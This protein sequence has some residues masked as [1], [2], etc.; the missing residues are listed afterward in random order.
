MKSWLPII[1][2]AIVVAETLVAVFGLCGCSSAIT[3]GS[4]H[5]VD[6][7]ANTTTGATTT[8]AR[9]TVVIVSP[10][11]GVE[12]RSGTAAAST[13]PT[14]TETA[15]TETATTQPSAR[16][17]TG[18]PRLDADGGI[19]IEPNA[20]AERYKAVLPV[21]IALMVIAVLFWLFGS[22]TGAI[23]CAGLA[24][25]AA[26][27]PGVVAW[28]SVIGVI[29]WLVLHNWTQIQQLIRG[30]EKVL[31]ALPADVAAKAKGLMA[32]AHDVSLKRVIR[33]VKGKVG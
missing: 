20:I 9:N 32:E 31:A 14:H 1:L 10:A 18:L 2:A 11:G 24:V 12:V 30:N 15:R 25:A 4:T 6:E 22:K 8:D 29:G 23:A 7:H 27:I 3:G 16:S 13:Q 26:W 28:A 19:S 21:V 5:K 17:T 33:R